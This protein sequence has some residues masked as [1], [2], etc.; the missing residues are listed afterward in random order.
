M[1]GD[2]MTYPAAR[3]Q[4]RAPETVPAW[5]LRAML[6]LVLA[7]LALVSVAVLTGRPTEGRPQSA[8]VL[9]E[10]SLILDGKSVQ[11]VTVYDANGTLLADLPRGGFVTVIQSGLE[12][13]RKRHGIDPLLPV[14]IKRF[15]NGRLAVEDPETGWSAELYAFGADNR[16]AFERLLA[17]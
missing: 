13:I 11:A 12:T 9:S 14:T 10:R 1:T 4:P 7:V 15:A 6:L 5:L 2:A 8:A 3:S 16:A 17:R